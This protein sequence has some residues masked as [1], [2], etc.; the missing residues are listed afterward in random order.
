M[1]STRISAVVRGV[2]VDKLDVGDEAGSGVGAFNEVVAEKRIARKALVEHG[3]ENGDFIDAFAR[4]DAFAVQVLVSVGNG[5]AVDVEPCL[6]GED[7]CQP[8]PRDRTD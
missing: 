5:P 2:V 8:R 1:F 6:A 3:M 7:G 4:E